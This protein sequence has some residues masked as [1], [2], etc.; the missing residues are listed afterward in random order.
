MNRKIRLQLS[1]LNALDKALQQLEDLFLEERPYL[2]DSTLKPVITLLPEKRKELE[3]K[4][5]Y[6]SELALKQ[7]IEITNELIT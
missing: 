4:V 7:R 1:T 3:Y 5:K 2:V 6:L